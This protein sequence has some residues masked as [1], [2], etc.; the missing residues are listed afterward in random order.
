[1]EFKY[2]HFLWIGV[3]AGLLWTLDYWKVFVRAQLY[4]PQQQNNYSIL[5]KL[6]RFI[7]L[8]QGLPGG[9]T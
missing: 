7:L 4:F 1:M 8:P 9:P 2:P 5:K 6:L 3:V